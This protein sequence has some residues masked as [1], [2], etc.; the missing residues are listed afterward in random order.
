ML[1]SKSKKFIFIHIFKTAGTSVNDVF[2]PYSRLIDRIA[3]QYKLT[4][5]ICGRF[6]GIMGWQDDG[7]KQITGF[8]KHAKASEIKEKLADYNNYYSFC[9]VRNPFDWMVSL[10]FYIKQDGGHPLHQKANEFDFKDFIKLYLDTKPSLQTD[11][12]LDPV[13]GKLI[14]SHVGRFETIKD[15]IAKITDKL[16][17]VD[18]DFSHKNK[19][20][21]RKKNDFRSYY[22]DEL[23][24]V[25]GEY[26]SK[27]L[28]LFGYSIDGY[29]SEI[30]VLA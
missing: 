25:V 11:F 17:V 9:F 6:I 16:G 2:V 22:D 21:H 29:T 13:T 15:D 26:F 30:P 28:E 5:S 12:V 23:E 24:K 3:Y 8:H 10:Y 14:V 18:Y 19:S 1:L 4:S 27:D 20:V 7:M